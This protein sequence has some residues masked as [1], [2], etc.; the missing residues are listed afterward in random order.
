VFVFVSENIGPYFYV[1][2]A[3]LA[4]PLQTERTDS[5]PELLRGDRRDRVCTGLG[6]VKTPRCGAPW[7]PSSANGKAEEAHP[8]IWAP[9]V[10]VGGGGREQSRIL[11]LVWNWHELPVRGTAAI[12][13]GI[14]GTS[15]VPPGRWAGELLTP[16]YGPAVRRKRVRRA[17]CVV[18][19]KCIRP[20]IG[21]RCSGPSWISARVRSD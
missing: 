7:L 19:H 1:G 20:L 9:F 10:L 4:A 17:G 18:L 6:R 16:M 5:P 11:L 8:S 15:A 2:S 3:V 14:S 12:P 21:A 13:S